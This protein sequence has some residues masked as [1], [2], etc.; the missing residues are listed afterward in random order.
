M[1]TSSTYLY[2]EKEKL[3]KDITLRQRSNRNDTLGHMFLKGIFITEGNMSNSKLIPITQKI[4]FLSLAF[5]KTL[6]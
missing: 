5:A 6:T 2:N 1:M 4:I 3:L